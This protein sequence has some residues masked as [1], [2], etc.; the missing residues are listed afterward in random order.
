MVLNTSDFKSWG[1][2][3][4]R[5]QR[6]V[7]LVILVVG[8]VVL[9]A[10]FLIF[11]LC[12]CVTFCGTLVFNSMMGSGPTPSLRDYFALATLVLAFLIL[13]PLG[14]GLGSQLVADV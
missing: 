1:K 2:E 12:S 9:I 5:R 3:R 8:R 14:R 6:G 13:L 11:V 10:L 4:V 7:L